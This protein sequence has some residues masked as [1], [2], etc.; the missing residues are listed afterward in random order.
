MASVI[1]SSV[2]G[3]LGKARY[4]QAWGGSMALWA[5][6]AIRGDL[7][8]HLEGALCDDYQF[9]RMVK[10]LGLRIYFVRSCLVAT[11]A[12]LDW[13]GL[14]N[15]AHRQ[16]LLTRV[17]APGLFKLVLVMV[18]FYVLANLSAWAGLV[19]LLVHDPSQ[20]H[21]WGIPLAALVLAAFWNHVRASMRRASVTNAL[22]AEALVNLRLPLMMDRW[23]TWLWMSIHLM[24]IVRACF[25]RTMLWRG[26]FYR[27]RGP[28]DV[29]R[30]NRS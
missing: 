26:I 24:L 23:L 15:F 16:Y 28:Q 14:V 1:N 7:R 10:K 18:G 12:A 19:V 30:M 8:G 9:G 2:I 11:P 6:T 17:Y 13:P 3:F 4:N 29:E 20:W 21:F 5:D 22:G 27:L 25:G